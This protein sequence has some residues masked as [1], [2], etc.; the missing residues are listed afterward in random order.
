MNTLFLS[1][2]GM[3]DPLGQS[4]VIPY[5]QGLVQAGYKVSLISFEKAERAERQPFIAQLLEKS[6]IDWHPLA[7]TKKPPILSTL[8]DVRA[9]KR[10]AMALHKKHPFGLIHCRSYIS[11]LVGLDLKRALGIPFIFDMRGFWADE[12]IDGGIWNLKNPVF[13]LVY[14]Y[15]K[16][17]EKAFLREAAHTISLTHAAKKIIHEQLVSNIPI[18]VIPCC[19]DLQLFSPQPSAQAQAARQQLGIPENALVLSY[20]GSIGTWYMLPEMLQFF[21]QLLQQEERA[22]FLFVTAEPANMVLEEAARL[23]IDARKF[24]IL[25]ANREE[26]PKLMSASD[27]SIFFIKPTFSKQASS[28]TKQGELMGMGIPI[29]CNAGVGDT[30]YVVQHYGSGWAVPD[31]TEIAF[32][33]GIRQI[34]RLRLLDKAKLREGAADF[35]ALS[36]GIKRYTSVYKNVLAL[37]PHE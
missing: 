10:K 28:P 12:R 13:R 1:Y 17:Q 5:L 30:D 27:L 2:D 7:Y 15:F 4:Q 19:A 31:C 36:E 37:Q 3:T 9:M 23:H 14:N 18:T 22:H 6:G 11:A 29:I 33:E 26:V 24:T 32:A 35:Y 16:R 8:K 21:K 25:K 20:L 34:P